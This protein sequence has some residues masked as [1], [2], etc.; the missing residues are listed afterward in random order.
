LKIIREV[1]PDGFGT[2]FAYFINEIKKDEK[3][4]ELYGIKHQQQP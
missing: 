1:I 3:E 2:D 4:G